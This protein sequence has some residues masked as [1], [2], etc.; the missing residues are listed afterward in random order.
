[1][2]P[3]PG[4]KLVLVG[5]AD[6]ENDCSREIRA[7]AAR[8]PRVVLPGFLS[9]R[10][11]GELFSNAG[12]FVLPSYHEGLPIALLEAMSYGL[13][14][15]ASDIPPNLEVPLSAERYFPV[16]D[17]RSLSEKLES[18]FA[19]GITEEEKSAQTDILLRKYDWD[20]I[21]KKTR[22]IYRDVSD[23]K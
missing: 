23:G 6:H 13:P 17:I 21:A 20:S 3:E 8:D 4:F 14:V 11:L 5:G 2:I 9:G 12:L 10:M 15:L 7:A 19:R 22:E 16:R 18:L 1:M